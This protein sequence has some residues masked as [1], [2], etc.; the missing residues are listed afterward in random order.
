MGSRFLGSAF[1]NDRRESAMAGTKEGGKVTAS[2]IKKKYGPDFY[3][4]IGAMGGAKSHTGGFY[5]NRDLARRAGKLGGRL[6]RRGSK[7][8]EK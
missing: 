6:S 8:A 1:T 3:A 4:R 7:H 5:G 2:K